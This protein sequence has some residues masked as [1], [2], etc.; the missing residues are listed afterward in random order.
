MYQQLSISLARHPLV[1][2]NHGTTSSHIPT[3]PFPTTYNPA[4]PDYNPNTSRQQ[5]NMRKK[6]SS[7]SHKMLHQL[8]WMTRTRFLKV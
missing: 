3:S 2:M 5:D 7:A 8:G 4:G 6:H 1:P